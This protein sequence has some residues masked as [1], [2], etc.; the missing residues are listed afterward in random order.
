MKHESTTTWLMEWYV[1]LKIWS[2]AY[3]AKVIFYN[4]DNL[5][6]EFKFR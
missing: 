4:K 2:Q 6:N 3:V 1:A 5:G